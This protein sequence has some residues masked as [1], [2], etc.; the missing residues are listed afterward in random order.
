[1]QD[2]ENR[3]LSWNRQPRGN[4][5]D[6]YS[7]YPPFEVSGN[8]SQ[9]MH[10]RIRLF[11]PIFDTSQFVDAL[12]VLQAA[13]EGDIVEVHLSTPGGNM[14]A[15]DTFLQAMHECEGRV[16][17]RAT[18]GCHS[19]GSIILM[20]AT[21][22]TL[23]ENFNMLIHNGSTGAGD[24][25]NKFAARAKFNVAYMNRV[26][27]TTYEGFLTPAEI[28]AMIEGK[29]FWIEGPEFM[30]RWECRQEHFR[31]KLS[32]DDEGQ[33]VMLKEEEAKPVAGPKKNK[34]AQP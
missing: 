21:E 33:F 23:S 20:N 17:I 5:G 8:R 3:G 22:F 11:G 10:F 25:L 14:D 7:V 16:I 12:E 2:T 18:G 15:T 29:D 4:S 6:Y 27:R 34:A 30:E 24:D 26:L 9:A 31:A 32:L 28:E 19:C 13:N 1:M